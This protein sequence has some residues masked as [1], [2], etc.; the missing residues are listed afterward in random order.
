MQATEN[1]EKGSAKG[2]WR[3][4]R[5]DDNGVKYTEADNLSETAAQEFAQRRQTQIGDHKQTI[6]AEPKP[7][8]PRP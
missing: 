4:I 2:G 8:V 6:W 7:P 5:Q 1:K 3:V